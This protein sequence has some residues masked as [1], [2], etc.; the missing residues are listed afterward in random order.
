[1]DG[2]CHA[3][4]RSREEIPLHA[5]SRGC[6]AIRGT[7]GWRRTTVP[8]DGLWATGAKS[9]TSSSF[10]PQAGVFRLLTCQRAVARAIGMVAGVSSHGRLG[11]LLGVQSCA[12]RRQPADAQRTLP[13]PGRPCCGTGGHRGQPRELRWCKYTSIEWRRCAGEETF[14]DVVG[15]RADSSRTP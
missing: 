4:E 2:G 14:L 6:G 1:M 3:A 5:R 9:T 10:V 8:V 7:A 15:T 13:P 12:H 11:R